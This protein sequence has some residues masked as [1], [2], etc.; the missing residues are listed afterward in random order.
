MKNEYFIDKNSNKE[1]SIFSKYYV[2][3]C[4]HCDDPILIYK[5]EIACA[6]FRHGVYKLNNE[7]INAHASKKTQVLPL[8]KSVDNFIGQ[9]AP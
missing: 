8:L 3:N 2:I 6:I 7:Q 4:P 1:D 9:I 5:D